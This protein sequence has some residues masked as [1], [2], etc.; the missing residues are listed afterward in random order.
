MILTRLTLCDFRVFRHI[1]HLRLEPETRNGVHCPITLIGGLNGAG[2]T[3]LLLA[4][5]L[6]LYGRHA[7]G[8]G[9]SKTNY[10]EFI[11]SCIHSSPHALVQPNNAFVELEFIYGKLG[12]QTRYIVRRSWYNA[13]G[14]V[15]ERLS[16]TEDGMLQEGL[17]PEACQGFLNELIPIGVAELFF[18]DGEKIAELAGDESGRVLGDAIHRLLG[19]DLMER[20]RNDLRVYMLRRER[21]TGGKEAARE[22]ELLQGEYDDVIK[23]VRGCEASLEKTKQNLEALLAERDR[24]ETHLTERGGEWGESRKAR[25]AKAWKLAEELKSDERVLRE[26]FAGCY[27][28]FL[29]SNVLVDALEIAARGLLSLAQ[30]EANELL[31]EFVAKLNTSLDPTGQAVVAEALIESIRPVDPSPLSFDISNRALGRMDHTVNHALHNAHKRVEQTQRRICNLKNALDNLTLQIEQAPD[32]AALA[33][34]YQ[35]LSALDEHINQMK[36]ETAVWRR[37]LRTNYT[38]AINLA[39]SLRDRHT[40]LSERQRSEL[41]LEY[42][43]NTRLL[44]KELRQT[45]ATRMIARLEQQFTAAFHR[46]ARKEYIIDKVLIDPRNFTVRLL[47]TNGKEVQKPQLS[48]GERQI[49]AIAMLEALARLSGRRLPVVIDTPLARL[50][51]FHRAN[52]VDHYFPNV[53]HQVVL[54]STDTE[55]D[56]VFFRRLSPRVSHAYEIQYDEK[57]HAAEL[58]EGYFSQT[59]LRK[60]S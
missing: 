7:M 19:L 58:R 18:F 38:N 11:R 50:D 29:A 56:E 4:L 36:A 48:A 1:H 30:S 5:K 33:A 37:E 34:D 8:M 54:L 53:S 43:D 51:S 28:L 32:E 42:A 47:N 39:R 17:A 25:R 49:Y 16:L 21:Q 15:R 12:R 60:V 22:I 44:L 31:E 46:L 2:K 41:S 9:T 6:A 14:E 13:G 24:I 20:L 10:S 3:T 35:K 59:G 52:L 26:E 55:V 45:Y 23:T 27:P 57:E 40:I